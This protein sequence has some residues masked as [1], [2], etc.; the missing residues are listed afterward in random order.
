M[1]GRGSEILKEALSLPP[2]ERAEIVERLLSS[3]DTPE[4]QRIDRLWAEEAEA[5]LAAYE[6][7]EMKA[8]PAAEVFESIG[9]K[10]K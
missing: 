2:E 4:R 6:R 5:R 10:R 7:G 9:A 1:S 3:L 8:I